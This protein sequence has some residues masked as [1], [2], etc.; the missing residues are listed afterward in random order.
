[1]LTLDHKNG[2]RAPNLVVNE[3]TKQCVK[4]SDIANNRELQ[5]KILTANTVDK[6]NDVLRMFN[7]DELF[8]TQTKKSLN[9]PMCDYVIEEDG[10][11]V[12][13]GIFH[14][15]KESNILNCKVDVNLGQLPK[16]YPNMSIRMV[17]YQAKLSHEVPYTYHKDDKGN[18]HVVFEERCDEKLKYLHSLVVN[19]NDDN[20]NLTFDVIVRFTCKHI[21]NETIA[22]QTELTT[23]HIQSEFKESMLNV[24]LEKVNFKW[25][26]MF[27]GL[28]LKAY[29][30]VEEKN[31]CKQ[32]IKYKPFGDIVPHIANA[33]V[34]YHMDTFL[35]R[36]HLH[37]VNNIRLAAT[38][39]EDEDEF[40]E[41]ALEH[42][43]EAFFS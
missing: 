21:P 13:M 3:E 14:K 38:I 34:C 6:I 19:H 26:K 20:I 23:A 12:V 24:I 39:Y 42:D 2:I 10:V 7:Y 17:W 9:F 35:S 32:T 25:S 41:A 37:D 22:F 33:S 31:I 18:L 27:D 1:M 36:I 28:F 29:S 16:K 30:N 43:L 40:L 11:K 5:C 4:L 8:Y 15:S